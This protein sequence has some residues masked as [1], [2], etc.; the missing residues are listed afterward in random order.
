MGCRKYMLSPPEFDPETGVRIDYTD[1]DNEVFVPIQYRDP[2]DWLVP[3]NQYLELR[4]QLKKAIE[5]N[6]ELHKE[7]KALK[8]TI[9]K[10]PEMYQDFLEAQIKQIKVFQKV[11]EKAKTGKKPNKQ[12]WKSLMAIRAYEDWGASMEKLAT[13]TRSLKESLEDEKRITNGSWKTS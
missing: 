2:D 8:K 4:D 12:E 13:L 1:L 6:E 7:N 5:D 11:Q 9:K 3:A 10:A